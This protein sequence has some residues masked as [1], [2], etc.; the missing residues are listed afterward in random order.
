M[1]KTG[2][3][4]LTNKPTGTF[5]P[6]QSNPL[7]I[8][9]ER[10]LFPP[11]NPPYS[12]IFYYSIYRTSSS[13]SSAR[14]Q[15]LRDSS[16]G[17]GGNYERSK[18]KTPGYIMNNSSACR[19]LDRSKDVKWS[20][21]VLLGP[22]WS[23]FRTGPDGPRSQITCDVAGPGEDWHRSYISVFFFDIGF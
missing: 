12:R 10:E 19:T 7:P 3:T 2:L 11:C 23:V 8:K 16:G 17:H 5:H 21:S 20:Y 14:D 18:R 15:R 6:M 9:R 13:S 22:T 4:L 1:R